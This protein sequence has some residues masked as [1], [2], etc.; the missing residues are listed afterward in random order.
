M[1]GGYQR[2]N[3]PTNKEKQTTTDKE[4]DWRYRISNDKLREITNTLPIRTFYQ[5]HH[6]KYLG[7]ICRLGNRAMQKQLLFDTRTQDK[8][9]KKMEK[10]LSVDRAQVRRAMMTKTDLMRLVDVNLTPPGAPQ[11]QTC[12]QWEI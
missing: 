4:A 8:V 2:I 11:G 9:W 5:R 6:I 1:K 12:A 3:A 7:H 10:L